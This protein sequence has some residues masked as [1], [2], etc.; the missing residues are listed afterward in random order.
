MYKCDKCHLDK[1]EIPY[2]KNKAECNYEV[3]SLLKSNPIMAVSFFFSGMLFSIPY[4]IPFVWHIENAY[5]RFVINTILYII[6]SWGFII[7][8]ASIYMFI[9]SFVKQYKIKD[10][11]TGKSLKNL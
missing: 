5:S 10:K 9:M 2:C 3:H 8:F 6:G 4:F 7:V 1:K 11:T